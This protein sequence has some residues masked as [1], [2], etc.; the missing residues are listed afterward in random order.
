[1]SEQQLSLNVSASPDPILTQYYE[2]LK[3]RVFYINDQIDSTMVDMVAIPLLM[4]DKESSDPITIY[5]NTPGG[6]P[7][8][9]FAICD[10]IE[11]L[12][13]PTKI[14]V[15]GYAY[16]MGAFIM[17]AGA[18]NPNVTRYCYNFSTCLIH[19]GS[20]LIEGTTSQIKDYFKFTE[21]FEEKIKNFVLE[22]SK[23]TEEE[24]NSMT[25]KE[26][27]LTSEDMLE[28][29]IVDEII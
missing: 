21:R 6:S 19:G 8:N 3:K 25:Q 27:W 11:Q 22:R 7:Y 14:I 10:I 4:A 29:G 24:Y 1:M 15:L 2:G 20:D 17:M 5:V 28:K 12:Q 18:N 9:G 16:S 23:I 26:A 13:S